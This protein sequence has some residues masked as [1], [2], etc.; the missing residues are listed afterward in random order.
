VEAGG[1]RTVEAWEELLGQVLEKSRFVGMAVP[2]PYGRTVWL[3]EANPNGPVSLALSAQHGWA[4]ES[5]SLT[6]KHFDRIDDSPDTVMYTAPRMVN[7]LDESSLSRLTGVYRQMFRSVA[8]GFA[9]LDLCS[10]WVSHFPGELLHGARVAV[11]GLNDAELRA[12]TQATEHHVQDLNTNS[13]LPWESE[14]FDFVTLALSVQYL[15]DPR[16]VFSEMHRVLK[17]GG[18]A[19]ITFSHR[20]FIEKAVQAWAEEPSDGE[21]HAHLISRYFQHGPCGGWTKLRTV[22][23]SPRHGDPLWLV[24]AVK[25]DLAE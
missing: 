11:H 3:P 20:C 21:G 9:V 13:S 5:W 12:N 17:P 10:S 16:A 7:H 19:L 2:G 6:P 25:A 18:M 15:T 23:A 1:N 4:P 22:D 8:P 14:S 24:T